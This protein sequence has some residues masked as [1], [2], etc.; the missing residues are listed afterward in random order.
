MMLRLIAMAFLVL[1][2]SGCLKTPLH[3][4]NVLSPALVDSIDIGDTRFEVESRLGE[5]ILED[6]LHPRRALYVE[7]YEDE[8]SGERIR[9][10]VV[11]IYDEAFRVQ[12]IRRFGFNAAD[13]G[14]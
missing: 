2:L 6:T 8:T 9:R 7:D 4:G 13:D 11:I 10:G 5:P 1:A 3:Q 12:D 14:N